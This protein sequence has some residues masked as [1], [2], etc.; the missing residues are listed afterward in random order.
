MGPPHSHHSDF[1]TPDRRLSTIFHKK[2][3]R[4]GSRESR[5]ERGVGSSGRWENRSKSSWKP[6]IRDGEETGKRERE[7]RQGRERER[8]ERE[9]RDRE[10]RSRE[11]RQGRK[12]ELQVRAGS[13]FPVLAVRD[14]FL[15]ERILLI[16]DN[17]DQILLKFFLLLTMEIKFFS[18][19][20]I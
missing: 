1:P 9:K 19:L 5:V 6:G 16:I 17:G 2:E 18:R 14:G 4:E 7:E 12:R 15:I 11:E 13:G 3:P 8:R 20:E 10:E